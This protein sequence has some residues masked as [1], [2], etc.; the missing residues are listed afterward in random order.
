MVAC[1]PQGWRRALTGGPHPSRSAPLLGAEKQPP[2]VAGPPF[3]QHAGSKDSC[4]GTATLV[5]SRYY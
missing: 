2:G 3:P 1:L 5:S 4:C